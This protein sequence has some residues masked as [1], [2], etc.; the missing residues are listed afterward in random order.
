MEVI[1]HEVGLRD[2]LQMESQQVPTI[3]KVQW[4][5]KLVEAGIDVIQLGSFVNPKIL[6]QMADTDELFEEMKS[7][8]ASNVRFSALILN[9]KGFERAL[10]A[11]ADLICMGVSASETHSKKNTGMTIA[12]ALERI[13]NIAKEAMK[14]GK[15]IQVSVQ[16]AFGCGYEGDIPEERVYKIVERYFSEG[17]NKVSLADTSGYAFPTKVERMFQTLQK[18]NPDAEFAAHFHNTYGLGIVNSYVAMQNGVKY[19]ET[20]FG[21]L[22]GCPFTKQPAGNVCTEDFVNMLQKM[23]LRN[24]INIGKIVSVTKYACGFF[25]KDLPGYL[26]K[27]WREQ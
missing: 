26:Y 9:E 16:S 15:D 24:D 10:K 27:T 3:T 13:I 17:I 1:I 7:K 18:M 8:K 4:A 11:D 22:G 5:E 23:G 21:G 20:A 14:L 6:P 12:E 19:I 2:G 25:I